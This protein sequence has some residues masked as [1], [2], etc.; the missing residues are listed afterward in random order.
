MGCGTSQLV[1]F[2][3]SLDLRRLESDADADSSFGGLQEQVPFD[4]NNFKNWSQDGRAGAK[5]DCMSFRMCSERVS[6]D[7]LRFGSAGEARRAQLS[8]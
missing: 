5:P 7:S 8:F 6:Y 1:L 3:I 4:F 2:R